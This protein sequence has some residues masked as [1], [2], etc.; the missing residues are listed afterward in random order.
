MKYFFKHI[1]L[2]W[3][4]HMLKL[5][6]Y[7]RFLLLSS[8]CNFWLLLFC[9]FLAHVGLVGGCC[10]CDSKSQAHDSLVKRSR[11]LARATVKCKW[12]NVRSR[13]GTRKTG[14]NWWIIAFLHLQFQYARLACDEKF[15]CAMNGNFAWGS[16]FWSRVTRNQSFLII[17]QNFALSLDPFTLKGEK[18]DFIETQNIDDQSINRLANSKWRWQIWQLIQ[19]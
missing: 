7:T 10:T 8:K 9:F 14:R 17:N 4:L 13:N 16:V 6:N 19:F 11:T 3:P 2:N 18:I 12:E 1:K 15:F 5:S